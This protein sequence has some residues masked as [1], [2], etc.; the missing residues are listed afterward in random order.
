MPLRLE[1]G[2]EYKCGRRPVF[3]V[4]LH[5]DREECRQPADETGLALGPRHPRANYQ[6]V[7]LLDDF[8]PQHPFTREVMVD[9]GTGEVSADR[10][11]LK[12]G[13]VVTEF[14]E[15]FARRLYDELTRL[16]CLRCGG[17]SGSSARRM[18]RHGR[19]V[20]QHT[21]PSTWVSKPGN[22][23]GRPA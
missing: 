12:G 23:A 1:H 17:A 4:R 3:G 2:G 18:L 19:I 7:R 20:P 6:R 5:R 11:R 13:G 21:G 8:A 9:G 22:P 10:D 16:G 14:A 15:D